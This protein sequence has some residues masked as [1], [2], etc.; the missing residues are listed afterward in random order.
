MK[1]IARILAILPKI[2]ALATLEINFIKSMIDEE[3]IHDEIPIQTSLIATINMW[4]NKEFELKPAQKIKYL[5]MMQ[6]KAEELTLLARA[7]HIEALTFNHL[8]GN[9]VDGILKVL[10]HEPEHLILI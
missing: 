10:V 4:G 6:S 5:A 9:T 2:L 1:N 8:R 3:S 7:N